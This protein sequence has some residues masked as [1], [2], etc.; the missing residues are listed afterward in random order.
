MTLTLYVIGKR[1]PDGRVYLLHS[2]PFVDIGIARLSLNA[3]RQ[4]EPDAEIF[5]LEI[6]AD[7]RGAV[8]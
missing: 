3:Y 1:W 6:E 5:E 2:G 8:N 4:S 7:L